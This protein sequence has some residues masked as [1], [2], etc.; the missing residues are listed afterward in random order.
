MKRTRSGARSR[1]LIWAS[2]DCYAMRGDFFTFNLLL[3][4]FPMIGALVGFTLMGLAGIDTLFDADAPMWRLRKP[5]SAKEKK[6]GRRYVSGKIRGREGGQPPL[7]LVIHERK[8]GKSTVED[9]RATLSNGAELLQKDGAVL[10]V[11]PKWVRWKPELL[12]GTSD[13]REALWRGVHPTM[14]AGGWIEQ[15]CIEQYEPVFI[16]GCISVQQG[17]KTIGP[18]RHDALVI[19]TGDGTAQPRIDEL[20][21]GWAGRLTAFCAAGLVLMLYGWILVRARPLALALSRWAGDPPSVKPSRKRIVAYVL[22]AT[23]WLALVLFNVL[24]KALE[25]SGYPQGSVWGHIFAVVTISLGLMLVMAVAKRR[26]QLSAAMEP[27]LEAPTV[28]LRSRWTIGDMVELAVRVRTN[29][30]PIPGPLTGEPRA[31]AG[32]TVDRVYRSGKSHSTVRDL[33]K[34]EPTLVPVEDESGHGLLD[35]THADFDIRAVRGVARRNAAK[36]EPFSRALKGQT[37]KSYVA[38]VVEERYLEPGEQLYVL[39]RITRRETSTQEAAYRGPAGIPVVG[40]SEEAKLIV[41][42]GSER[43]L[44]KRIR[45]ERFYLTAMLGA[46]A[47]MT[48]AIIGVVSFATWL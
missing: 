8:S 35:L 33:N 43:D 48:I 26:R 4:F 6:A 2:P 45:T 41:H 46:V 23:G 25:V 13:A 15:H 29:V 24:F 42:A 28:P 32:I 47:A 40:G 5:L 38:F 37:R 18:C 22:L 1:F 10:Q 7:C 14:P 21:S 31:Y 34:G 16:D 19:T 44:L 9:F 27:V 20:A 12:V 11:S 36:R 30:D 39:G 3:G 17:R